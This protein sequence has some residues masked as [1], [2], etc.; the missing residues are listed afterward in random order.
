MTPFIGRRSIADAVFRLNMAQVLCV[1][2]R[3]LKGRKVRTTQVF[4]W[5]NVVFLDCA[6]MSAAEVVR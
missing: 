6:T 1:L 3:Q 5:C 2:F 4:S